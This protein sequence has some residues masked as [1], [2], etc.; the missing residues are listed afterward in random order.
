MALTRLSRDEW[1]NDYFI[2]RPGEHFA[3]IEP[4]Q[5]GKTRIL[6]QCLQRAMQQNPG[7]STRVTIPKRRDGESARWNSALGL[8]ETPHWPPPRRKLWEPA[9]PG[10]ALWPRH[11][12]G[13]PDEDPDKV[14]AADRA[15]VRHEICACAQDSYQNGDCI[16]VADDIHNQATILDMNEFFEEMLTM[17]GAMGCGLWGANQKPSGSQGSGGITSFF[18]NSPTHLLIGK[19]TDERNRKR[20]GEIGGVDPK[21]ISAVVLN[22]Q[23]HHIDGHN[24]SDKLYI[25]KAGSSEYGPAMCIV[26]P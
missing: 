15:H 7:L 22:L 16:H 21:Y 13:S 2:Y 19:D 5:G 26:G 18:Y 14:L 25:T 8:S 20:F 17:G 9:P 10:Y 4:T 12:L 23:V 1:L 6:Y 3:I 24:I 11:I